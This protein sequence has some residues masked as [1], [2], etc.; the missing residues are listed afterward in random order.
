MLKVALPCPSSDAV[1]RGEGRGAF[2]GKGFDDEEEPPVRRLSRAEAAE[3]AA[4]EPAISPWRVVAAQ[5]L[6]GLAIASAVQLATG[7]PL[8][9]A[10]SLY[11]AAVVALPGALMAR[12][13][14]SRLGTISPLT[15]TVNIMGWATVKI[16][17]SIVMLALAA[18]IVPGLHWPVMLATLVVCMQ[19]YAFALLW[20]ARGKRQSEHI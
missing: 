12:G 5:V 4:R 17:V 15:S 19:T 9:F 16:V 20:R 1:I 11:G 2:R 8:L 6:V 14:T 7:D 13:A 18:R 3:L 10:S